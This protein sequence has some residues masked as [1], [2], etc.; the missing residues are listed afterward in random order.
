MAAAIPGRGGLLAEIQGGAR[1]KK[2]S[3]QEK[4]DRSAAVATGEHGAAGNS[5]N[6]TGGGGADSGLA[7]ALASALAARKSKVSASGKCC[8]HSFEI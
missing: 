1:L 7:G 6:A 8:P 5:T 4:R 3:A 2:V